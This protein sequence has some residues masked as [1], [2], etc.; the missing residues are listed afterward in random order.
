[1]KL[2]NYQPDYEH[3]YYCRTAGT[4]GH[5]NQRFFK[6]ESQVIKRDHTKLK[7]LDSFYDNSDNLV[8]ESPQTITLRGN[9][10]KADVTVSSDMTVEQFTNAMETAITGTGEAVGN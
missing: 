1:M 9:G 2:V 5:R 10:N 3:M 4:K 6:T 8:I 7:D